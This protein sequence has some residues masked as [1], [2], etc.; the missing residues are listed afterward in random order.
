M[1]TGLLVYGDILLYHN[2]FQERTI[3]KIVWD[4]RRI[5]KEI[6]KIS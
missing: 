2:F 1:E 5:E 3:L 4:E 6:K